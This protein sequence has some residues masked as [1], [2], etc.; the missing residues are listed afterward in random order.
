MRFPL[1]PQK[2][3]LFTYPFSIGENDV[4]SSNMYICVLTRY[5]VT[6][7]LIVN[8]VDMFLYKMKFFKT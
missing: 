4:Q 2:R 8:F 1:P 3:V 5:S 6:I 7:D